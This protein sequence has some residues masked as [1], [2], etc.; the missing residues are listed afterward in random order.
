MIA[1]KLARIGAVAVALAVCLGAGDAVA[2]KRGRTD[3]RENSEYGKGGYA[4]PG[5]DRFSLELNW[6][7]S[8]VAGQSGPAAGPPLF[9]GGTF[10]WW[11]DEFLALDISGAYLFDSQRINA[12]VGPRFR[13]AGWM[14]VSLTAGLK[15]GGII[16]PD[17]VLRFGISPQV[18]FD[19][20]VMDTMLAGLNYALDIPFGGGGVAH[21]IFMSIG[22]RF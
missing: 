5:A 18:G 11:G 12:M 21:R 2:Q 17:Q 4:G 19:A 14:P 1:D 10:S 9:A 6:G 16:L 20:V 13:A 22:Y 3:G 8:S 15:A 7:Y